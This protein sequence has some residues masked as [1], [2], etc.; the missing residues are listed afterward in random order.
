MA[1]VKDLIDRLSKLDGE[2]ELCA[3]VLTREEFNED[4]IQE[5]MENI[6]DDATF[7][8]FVDQFIDGGDIGNLFIDCYG[9]NLYELWA[10]FRETEDEKLEVE[11]VIETGDF[12]F[13]TDNK[14][15]ATL[16]Q[17]ANTTDPDKVMSIV[18]AWSEAAMDDDDDDEEDY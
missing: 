7:A 4:I 2:R 5:N 17:Q 11:F 3:V 14:E 6:H 16:I 18:D 12:R 1:K 8:K 15:L 13:A 9:E 10:E